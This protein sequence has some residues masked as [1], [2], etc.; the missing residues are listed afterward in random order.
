VNKYVITPY[1]SWLEEEK[2]NNIILL[3]EFNSNTIIETLK[4][5]TSS[6]E[7]LVFDVKWDNYNWK[8]IVLRIVNF[9]T[10]KRKDQDDN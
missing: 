1:I 10:S 2:F 9:I 6:N 3:K 5:I 4:K 8:E 7:E